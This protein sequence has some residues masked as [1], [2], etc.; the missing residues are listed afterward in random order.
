[1]RRL[2]AAACGLLP[3]L[4]I[5]G[6]ILNARIAL[7]LGLV[8]LAGTA[9]DAATLRGELLNG[10]TGGPGVADRIEL[11]DVAQGMEP[12]ATVEDV[13][14]AFEIADVPESE[15]HLLLRV[16]RGDVTF[17]QSLEAI[18]Q[19]VQLEVY[20]VTRDLVGVDMARHHVIFRRDAE[21]MLVTELFEFE[22]ASDPPMTI[23]ADALPMRFGFE[24]PTH[25]A[26]Q[27]SVGS[28]EFPITL[29]VVET[30]AANVRAVER[31]LRPGTT[32]MFVSYAIEYDPNGTDWVNTNVY[33]A[34]DRRVLVAPP[35]VQVMVESMIPSESPME[36][37]AAYSGLP[38]EAGTEWSVRL[39]GGTAMAQGDPHDH[40]GTQQV[41]RVEVRPHRFADQRIILMVLVGALLL[42]G[43]LFGA[44]RRPTVATGGG[45]IDSKRLA[46]SRLADRYVSGELTREQFEAERDRLLDSRNQKASHN[47]QAKD[48]VRR[49]STTAHSN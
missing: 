1:M 35:D 40:G 19:P 9:A 42:F 32:R 15:A 7:S 21:H 5:G 18:D 27:A 46:L 43:L 11:I 17:S 48:A 26:P 38:V 34:R 13:S 22:N 37:F 25:G 29:P 47:G 6:G 31:A 36:G 39:A 4:R 24:N 44:S 28:G 45:G 12:L 3:L 30:D 8:L 20:E 16:V 14:G 10:T 33:G 49:A 41:A 23:V 2:V